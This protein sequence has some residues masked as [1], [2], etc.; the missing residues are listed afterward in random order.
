MLETVKTLCSLAGPSGWEDEVRDSILERVLPLADAVETD[1]MGNL[2]VFCRGRVTLP[3]PVMVCAH[4]DEVGII[5]TGVTDEGFLKFDFIGGVDRRVT[6]GRRVLIGQNRI[7][8]IIGVKA[9]HLVSDDEEKKVPKTEEL[10]LDIGAESEAEALERVHL[11]DCGI[12]DSTP[13]EMGE[14]L[15]K[16]R[17][18]DDRC[19]CAAM[20]KLME[21]ELPCD[22]WFVFTV[23]E[24]VGA[25]GGRTAAYRIDPALCLVLEGTTAADIPGVAE[26]KRI[27]RVG[28]G[29]VIPFMDGGTLYDRGLYELAS[30]TAE[31]NG[32][33]WQTK[34]MIAGGTDASGI[35]RS[36]GGVRTLALSVAMRNIHSPACVASVEDLENLPR[37]AALVLEELVNENS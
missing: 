6:M 16:A 17:A 4:M 35:Q 5:V 30:K 9:Y 14:G 25:R 8:A 11:G 12:F 27:C 26:E 22:T 33:A 32:I 24:E 31:K 28:G 34:T 23:Q 37:L 20:L 36:R 3:K 29:V 21:G 18:I 19:G 2:L 7:P 1:P 10:Y 13:I 15:L